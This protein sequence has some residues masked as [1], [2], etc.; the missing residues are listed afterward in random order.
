MFSSPIMLTA[1]APWAAAL[2]ALFPALIAGFGAGYLVYREVVRRRMGGAKAES[3]RM[4][5]DA[6]LEA[7]TLRKDALLE[8][9]EEQ[10][11]L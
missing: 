9:K 5:E 6:R 8:A 1:L 7:K 10:I 11:R 2:I 3:E 4:I